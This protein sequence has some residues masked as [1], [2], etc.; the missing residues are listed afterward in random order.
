MSLAQLRQ[1]AQLQ[2]QAIVSNLSS[3][4]NDQYYFESSDEELLEPEE[5]EQERLLS[6]EHGEAQEAGG[7]GRKRTAAENSNNV[8]ELYERAVQKK[9]SSRPRPTITETQLTSADGL[10]R[11]P[12]EV[13]KYI[14]KGSTSSSTTISSVV[15][16]ARYTSRM[17]QYYQQFTTQSLQPDLSMEDSLRL[18]QKLG[19]QT[20]VKKY[21]KHLRTNQRNLYLEKLVGKEVAEEYIQQ[22]QDAEEEEE[23]N[24]NP[25][26]EG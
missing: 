4:N 17:I 24:Y 11:L 26:T 13:P 1:Q 2:K 3:R 10:I 23:N 6:E 19:S 18:I 16:A 20:S 12:N 15:S 21:L 14:R 9:K 25:D 7:G 22:L 5:E 8:D